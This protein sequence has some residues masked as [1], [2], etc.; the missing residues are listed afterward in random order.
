MVLADKNA[1][2]YEN[3]KNDVYDST[4]NGM[5]GAMAIYKFPWILQKLFIHPLA[6]LLTRIPPILKLFTKTPELMQA[7][8]E[9]HQF[10]RNYTEKME[11]AGVD[12]ILCPG[13]MLP[14]P[15]TG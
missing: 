1:M 14:A 4:L 3:L 13:Q 2:M 5:V 12:V 9:K 7:M 8:E 6:S 11:E 10:I 15:P